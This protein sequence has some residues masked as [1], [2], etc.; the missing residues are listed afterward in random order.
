M[1]QPARY[2]LY[3]KYHPQLLG[4]ILERTTGMSITEFTQTRL[5]D[6]IGMEFSGAWLRD[7]GEPVDRRVL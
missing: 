4:M 5:W 2:F 1:D 3:N 7:P 6:P